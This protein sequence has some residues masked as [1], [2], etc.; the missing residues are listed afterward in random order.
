[1]PKECLRYYRLRVFTLDLPPLRERHD[2]ILLLASRFLKVHAPADKQPLHLTPAASSALVS[3]QWSGNVRELENVMIRCIHF[4]RTGVIDVAELG[5]ETSSRLLKEN[6][7]V[8]ASELPPFKIMKRKV[9]EEFERAYLTRLMSEHNGNV[10]RAVRASGKERR[11]LGKLLK[12]H[13]IDPS[14]FQSAVTIH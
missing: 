12:K 7:L 11:D 3:H 8:A 2:D 13:G 4:D 5:L 10:S 9:V 14:R 6:T 1:M